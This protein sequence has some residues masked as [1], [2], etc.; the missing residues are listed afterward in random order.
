MP[1]WRPHGCARH[2]P[3]KSWQAMAGSS[4][5]KWGSIESIQLVLHFVTWAQHPYIYPWARRNLSIAPQLC[6]SFS[7]SGPT[8][9]ILRKPAVCR[10]PTKNSRKQRTKTSTEQMWQPINPPQWASEPPPKP[11]QIST[12]PR[13]L[14]RRARLEEIC[15]DSILGLWIQVLGQLQKTRYNMIIWTYASTT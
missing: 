2:S 10:M 5:W 12:Q 3:P 13:H 8:A 7:S 9:T 14:K 4:S 11:P 6:D 15:K 1:W